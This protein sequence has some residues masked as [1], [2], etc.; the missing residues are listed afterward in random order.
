M[1]RFDDLKTL[2][3]SLRIYGYGL[4]LKNG[5]TG[6]LAQYFVDSNAGRVKLDSSNGNLY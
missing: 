2:P 3:K 4:L 5:W 1:G 6:K